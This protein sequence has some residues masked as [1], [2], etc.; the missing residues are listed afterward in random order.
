LQSAAVG[1]SARLDLPEMGAVGWA[2]V[3]AV[4]PCP[5]LD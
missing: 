2:R 5:P 1:G 3:T 4:E